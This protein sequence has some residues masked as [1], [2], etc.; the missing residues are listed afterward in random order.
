MG[1]RYAKCGLC[2]GRGTIID[3]QDFTSRITCPRC[4]GTG[5][6]GSA[7]HYSYNDTRHEIEKENQEINSNTKKDDK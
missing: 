2:R 4:D 5:F 1:E 6:S 3:V 7:H